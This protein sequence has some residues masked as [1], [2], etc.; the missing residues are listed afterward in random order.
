MHPP[1]S[2]EMVGGYVRD[3]TELRRFRDM[4]INSQLVVAGTGRA[5]E[6]VRNCH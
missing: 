6:A 3:K 1:D 5:P 4:R 2:Q